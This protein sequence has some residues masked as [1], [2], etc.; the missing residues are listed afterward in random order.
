MNYWVYAVFYTFITIILGELII[1]Q[2]LKLMYYMVMFLLYICLTNIYVTFNYYVK[3]RNTKGIKGDRGDPGPQG[4]DGNNGVCVMAKN[5]SIANCRNLVIRELEKQLNDYKVIREKQRKQ[6]KLNGTQ[7]KQLRQI[8]TYIDILVQQC[9]SG[10][11]GVDSFRKIIK[12]KLD[13]FNN[14]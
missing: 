2:D 10:D 13:E 5:C 4:Q 8:N 11:K 14:N 12:T 1:E 7:K 9:E 3:L 6:L